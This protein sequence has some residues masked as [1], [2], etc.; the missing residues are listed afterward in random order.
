MWVFEHFE[1]IGLYRRLVDSAL[2][3]LFFIVLRWILI[4]IFLRLSHD[5]KKDYLWRKGAE[6]CAVFVLLFCLAL[7]WLSGFGSLT[8]YLGLLSAGIAVALKDPLANFAGCLFIVLRKPFQVGDRIEI[9]SY[10]GDVIDID[11]FQFTLMESGTSGSSRDM[12]T[13]RVIKISNSTMFTEP[14]VNFTKGWFEYVY[15][16]IEVTVTFESNWKKARA[17]L[18]EIIVAEARGSSLKA[19]ETMTK[20]AEKYMVLAIRLDPIVLTEVSTNGITLTATY[21]CDSRFKRLSSSKVWEQVLDR[22]WAEEDIA[23]AYPT[24][25]GFN[26][27]TEG[28][29]AVKAPIPPGA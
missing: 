26:N 18:E 13:G 3:I 23:F 22:Y 29:A 21:L 19:K 10:A 9:G 2:A 6:Y 17:I 12:R 7:V 27:T 25:R 11:V 24:Q 20:A 16:T 1:A 4:R 8:T 14:L 5:R 15:N 28:K